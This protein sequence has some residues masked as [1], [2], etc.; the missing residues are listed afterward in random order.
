ML[1]KKKHLWV[2]AAILLL[3]TMGCAMP[4]KM[5]NPP[6][7]DLSHLKPLPYTAGLYI[8]QDLKSY[9]HKVATSP[10]DAVVYPLGE[11]TASIFSNCTAK[12]FNKVVPVTSPTPTEQ[13]DVIIQPAIVKFNAVIPVPAYNPYTATMVYQADVLRPDGQK[14]FSQTATGDAQ[15]SKGL[16]SGFS[17]RG[18]CAKVAQDAMVDAAQQIMEAIADSEEISQMR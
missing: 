6:T 15:S 16:M 10:F 18:I 17:A 9:E 1:M 7:P 12:I 13:V 2:C 8:P 11:Q 5:G 3:F 4:L 14:V